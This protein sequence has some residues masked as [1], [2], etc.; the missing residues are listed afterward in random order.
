MALKLSERMQLGKVEDNKWIF[1]PEQGD[2][3]CTTG[4]YF[5]AVVDQ[6]GKTT[7][8]PVETEVEEWEFDALP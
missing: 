4:E 6:Y 2:S 7:L 5:R 8:M 1:R 3:Y